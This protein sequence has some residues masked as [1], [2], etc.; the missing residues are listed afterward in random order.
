MYY[1]Q[2]V[3]KVLVCRVIGSRQE[4]T[5]SDDERADSGR[6]AFG[7]FYQIRTAFE[8]A[9]TVGPVPEIMC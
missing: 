6:F 1:T 4:P 5:E 8:R 7:P 2:S 9:N 3:A